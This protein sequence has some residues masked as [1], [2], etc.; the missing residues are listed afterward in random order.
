MRG[1]DARTRATRSTGGAAGAAAL[2]AEGEARHLPAPVRR[3]VAARP[4]RL[5]AAAGEAAR[6]QTARLGA[7]GAAPH[8]HDQRADD[9]AGRAVDVRVRA[10]RPGGRL[11][12][13]AAAAHGEDRR[14]HRRHPVDAHRGDQPRP[15]DHVHPDRH[16]QPGRPSIG[17]WLSYGLGSENQN[18]PAFVVLI[19]QAHADHDRPAALLAAVGQRLPAVAASGRALPRRR[20]PGALPRRSARHRP[21]TTRGAMLD[22]LGEAERD[23]ARGRTAI[24][25]SRRA[26]RSTRWPSGC[27]R[28]VP[29]LTD[30]SKEPDAMLELYGPEARKPGTFAANCLL[31]RRLA[32]RGVRFVQLYHRG[33]DQHGNLPQRHRAAVQGHRPADRGAHHGPQAARPARRHARDLGRRVRAHGLQPGQADRG[34]LRP[35]PPSALLLHL[36]GRRRHQARRGRTARPTTSATTSSRTRSTCT[37]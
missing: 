31:A 27:R 30:L 5:Q 9:A 35:R 36:D 17:A 20:R 32:E 18:L 8:R 13:R 1:A 24:R 7:H 34:Q 3:A 12:Q 28:R 29:E 10:A 19:S 22:A 11:G 4:V 25:R 21:R 14:R 2:R 33:W 23:A 16:Q 37:T 26:S 15:G 6:T